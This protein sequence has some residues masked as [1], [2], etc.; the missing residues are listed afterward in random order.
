MAGS[1]C[2]LP[3]ASYAGEIKK[4]RL[5]RD[6]LPDA[7]G[8]RLPHAL[9]RQRRKGRA[10]RPSSSA[11]PAPA[12]PPF[13][14]TPTASSSATTSTAGRTTAAFNFEGGC[15]AKC[16]DLSEESEPEIYRRHP[17]R[18]TGG[19]RDCGQG[20][21]RARTMWTAVSRK[22]PG[23]AIPVDYIPNAAIPGV[24]QYTQDRHLPHGGRLRRAAP[25]LPA[26]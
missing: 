5:L 25:H 22:I 16:I 21:P 9:L 17:L 10:T 4:I 14:P 15:Y 11:S 13:P 8:G 6:E 2:S 26:G 12:R 24:G 23:W 3:A 18:R 7:Q 20:D 19:K 1:W